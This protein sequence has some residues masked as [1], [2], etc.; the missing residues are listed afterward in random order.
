MEKIASLLINRILGKFIKG[1]N[2]KTLKLSL[3]G[4]IN[5]HHLELKEN[6][7]SFLDIPFAIKFGIIDKIHLKIPWYSIYKEQSFIEISGLYILV[8]SKRYSEV[9]FLL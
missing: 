6:V 7:L 3:L 5:L 4:D 9:F 2:Y 8:E 1:F